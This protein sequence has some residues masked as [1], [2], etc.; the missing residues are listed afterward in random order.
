MKIRETKCTRTIYELRSLRGR[1]L[2]KK[3]KEKVGE[4]LEI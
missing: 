1:K 3:E 2:K 4:R